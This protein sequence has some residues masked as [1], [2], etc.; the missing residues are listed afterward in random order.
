M[1][2]RLVDLEIGYAHAP[3]LS[4]SISNS[5]LFR[6]DPSPSSVMLVGFIILV[7]YSVLWNL[8][9]RR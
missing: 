1:A 4:N 5:E 6:S 3:S 9:S 8:L 7:A 2:N